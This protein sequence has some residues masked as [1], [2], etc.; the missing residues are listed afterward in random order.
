LQRLPQ[1][2]LPQGSPLLPILFLFFNADLV[3]SRIDLDGGS[4]AFVND[5]SSWVTGGTTEENG[6][7]IP[8]RSSLGETQRGDV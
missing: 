3:Q 5:C 4:F 2:G 1:A 7:G 8:A 6:D